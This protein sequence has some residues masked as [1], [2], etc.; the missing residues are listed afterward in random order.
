MGYKIMNRELTAYSLEGWECLRYYESNKDL[1]LNPK[2]T[3]YGDVLVQT[4]RVV[5]GISLKF[6]FFFK[7]HWYWKPSFHWKYGNYYFHFLFFMFWFDFEY[8][9]KFDKIIKD[10]VAEAATSFLP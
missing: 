9:E 4:K 1:H 8:V 10:H 6:K 3:C 2:M 7:N 5:S